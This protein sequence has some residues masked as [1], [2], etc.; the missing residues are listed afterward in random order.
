MAGHWK[1][2]MDEKDMLYAHDLEGR[3]IG[4]AHV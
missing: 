1:K 4:R 3:E 2:M